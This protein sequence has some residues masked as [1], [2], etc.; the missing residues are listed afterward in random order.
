MKRIISILLLTYPILVF[1]DKIYFKNDTSIEGKIIDYKG[2]YIT[3]K[4]DSINDV[5]YP[6][7]SVIKMIDS[8]TIQFSMEYVYM[9]TDSD[10]E[11]IAMRTGQDET[12]IGTNEIQYQEKAKAD[13]KEDFNSGLKWAGISTA[14]FIGGLYVGDDNSLDKGWLMGSA[15]AFAAPIYI[16]H[17]IPVDNSRLY[18]LS[19]KNEKH[20]NAYRTAYEKEIRK[21]RLKSVLLGTGSSTVALGVIAAVA[22]VTI[23]AIFAH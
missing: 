6:K 12:I 1:A 8:Q 7:G 23:M 18:S 22:V 20:R 9:A 17:K 5:Q 3:F 15:V 10:G 21:Q 11:I 16:I 19:T 13:A 14:A 2:D 4:L